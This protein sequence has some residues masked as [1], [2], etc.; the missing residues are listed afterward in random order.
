MVLQYEFMREMHHKERASLVGWIMTYGS[1]MLSLELPTSP[2]PTAFARLLHTER[3]SSIKGRRVQG[4]SS[5]GSPLRKRG[6]LTSFDSL[7]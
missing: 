6:H 7:S 1:A 4:G 3:A 5:R 2:I